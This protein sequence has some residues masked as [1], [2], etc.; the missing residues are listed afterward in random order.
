[1]RSAIRFS[2]PKETYIAVLAILG[3]FLHLFFRFL[4]GTEEIVS[5]LPLYFV[6]LLGGIPLIY[7]LSKKT[8]AGEFG[9]DLLAGI[10]I[11]TAVILGEFLVGSIVVLMLSG[12]TA[13]E[14]FAS[15]RASSVLDALAKRIP[16][17]A[18]RKTE[19]G[20]QDI[21]LNDIA[22]GAKLIVLPHEICPVDGTV[23]EGHGSMDESYLTGEPYDMA[24]APGSIVLSGAINGESALT[25]EATKLPIDSRYAKIMQVMQESSQRRPTLR[26]I[27]DSLGA[28]YTPIA[29]AIAILTWVISGESIRFLA[30]LVI[31]TPCPL[32]I[33]IPVTII[34]AISL[35]ARNAIIIKNPAILEQVSRCR[36]FIFDKTGTLTYGR[37]IL[38]DTFCAAGF[39]EET[40][41]RKVA[42]LE[43]YSKHP[44]AS[45]ILQTASLREITLEEV[46]EVIE[47]PGEGLRGKVGSNSILITGRTKLE[48][49]GA[50]PPKLPPMTTGLEC[51]VFIDGAYA[52]TMKFRDQPRPES[53]VFVN[54]LAPKHRV[55]K[56]ILLSGDRESEVKYLAESVGI[57]EMYFGKSPE[58]KVSIVED[59]TK[60]EPTLFVGDGINDAPAMQV[61]T[62]GVA[63]G[64]GSDIT[65]EAAD[66]TILETSLGKI[67]Q[68]LHI[69]GRMRVI[70]LQSAVGGMSLSIIGMLLAATGYLNP[71]AGAVAQEIID[72]LAVLNAVRMAIPVK[73]LTDY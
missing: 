45:A 70:A 11:L 6:L 48:K 13:L 16:Q 32:L 5:L 30:V 42:S 50:L 38:T 43:E 66:A 34:G 18:H 9:S 73:K 71:I 64:S 15:R 68:L 55:N 31:A 65:T 25:I 26:R 20:I 10:S 41:L 58:E 72:L 61:A 22:I 1:M 27:G 3:I 21:D 17:I 28:V 53:N 4:I 8:I 36:T 12:G 67:D 35:S 40:V 19:S 56:I 54:H 24:K 46:D 51:I 7:D 60:K 63:F 39:S 44:L 37:P 47:K 69:G 62:V 33:A 23:V 2:Y 59:E 52:A 14:Q 57:S 29:V 49:M